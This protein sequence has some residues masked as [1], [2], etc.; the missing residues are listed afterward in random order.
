MTGLGAQ[1]T[2][3]CSAGI[4]QEL[5]CARHTGDNSSCSSRA[6]LLLRSLATSTKPWDRC[7]NPL[8]WLPPLVPGQC[9]C[10]QISSF[11]SP[12]CSLSSLA[13]QLGQQAGGYRVAGREGSGK[14][15]PHLV[16]KLMSEECSTGATDIRGYH[17]LSWI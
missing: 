8:F 3:G 11:L 1:Q 9:V 13:S 7:T 12:L 4:R 16:A 2:L 15:H 10:L 6:C 14:G 17:A 5:P